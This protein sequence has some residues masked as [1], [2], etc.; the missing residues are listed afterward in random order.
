M[1]SNNS[2]DSLLLSGERV[3][4]SASPA[5]ALVARPKRVLALVGKITL[6]FLGFVILMSLA[7]KGVSRIEPDMFERSKSLVLLI[8]ALTLI[9][10]AWV[11]AIACVFSFLFSLF[12]SPQPRREQVYVLTDKRLIVVLSQPTETQIIDGDNYLLEAILTPNG[13]VHDLT[14]WFAP[15]ECGEHLAESNAPLLLRALKN[16]AEAQKE[17]VKRFGPPKWK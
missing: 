5:W 2:I 8:V 10:Y 16:G 17:I 15:R 1:A 3:E 6:A 13:H 14:L 12:K 9:I 4:W 11:K 7:G